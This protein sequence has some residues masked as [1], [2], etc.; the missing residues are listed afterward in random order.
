MGSRSASRNGRK[1]RKVMMLRRMMVTLVMTINKHSINTH[2]RVIW[3]KE[4]LAVLIFF[5]DIVVF[6]FFCGNEE[7]EFKEGKER[8]NRERGGGVFTYL[9]RFTKRQLLPEEI[10]HLDGFDFWSLRKRDRDRF[11]GRREIF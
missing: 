1:R 10:H 3:Y 8:K 2:V 4:V 9:L 6:F 11:Y 7:R 5:L